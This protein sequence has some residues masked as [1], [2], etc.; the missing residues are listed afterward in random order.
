MKVKNKKIYEYVENNKINIEK[1]M[2]EYTNYIHV[3]IR[4]FNIQLSEEDTEEI[5]LDVFLTIWKNQ[6]KLNFN[7]N[8]SSYIG[9]VTKN[10]IKY[11]LRQNKIILNIEDYDEKLISNEDIELVLIENERKEIIYNELENL[12]KDEKHIFLLYYY[13]EK[14]VKEIA[15]KMNISESKVKVK[16]FRIRKKM[17]KILN[18]GGQKYNG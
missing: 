9:G 5:V 8:I 3:I 13:E 18:E 16:L 10:L 15:N 14:N 11:K 6:N 1:I 7:K 17:K 2:K 4:N 12:K